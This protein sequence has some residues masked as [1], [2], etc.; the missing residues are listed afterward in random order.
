MSN[1]VPK[2]FFS[3]RS[4]S[5]NWAPGGQRAGGKFWLHV[6]G[7]SNFRVAKIGA[8][9]FGKNWAPIVVLHRGGFERIWIGFWARRLGFFL[10]VSGRDTALRM[11]LC[12][13][14]KKWSVVGA[15]RRNRTEKR[16]SN[17][18]IQLG[19]A[20]VV[21][22]GR[23]LSDGHPLTLSVVVVVSYQSGKPCYCLAGALEGLCESDSI[24]CSA[25]V[26]FVL[27]AYPHIA[28]LCLL[29]PWP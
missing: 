4:W 11:C 9:P 18:E 2:T 15:C 16:L 23:R 17:Q 5:E 14:T 24:F 1:F 21:S 28:S 26:H 12:A 27:A 7:V 19:S 6:L 10:R 20:L 13:R 22:S 3:L 25:T 8:T 29:R